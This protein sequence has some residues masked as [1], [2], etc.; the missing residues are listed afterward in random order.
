LLTIAH[1]L[2]A[3]IL[4]SI[5][6]LTIDNYSDFNIYRKH[7]VPSGLGEKEIFIDQVSA[8]IISIGITGGFVLF[9]ENIIQVEG[10]V[11][12]GRFYFR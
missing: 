3:I 5:L 10:E 7:K 9:I 1:W 6:Q 8:G 2:S 12:I 11:D 4:P